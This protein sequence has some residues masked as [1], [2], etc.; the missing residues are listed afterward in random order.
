MKQCNTTSGKLPK[1]FRLRFPAFLCQ[2]RT[3]EGRRL[4]K[5]GIEMFRYKSLCPRMDGV[6]NTLTSVLKDNLIIHL[7]N[8]DMKR[9]Y[10]HNPTNDDL[11]DY[12]APRIAVR[13]MISR[14]S[15]RLM[16]VPEEDIDK[17]FAW[18]F[19]TIEERQKAIEKADKKELSRIKR[20]SICKTAQFKLAGNSIVVDCLFHIFRTLFIPNQPENEPKTAQ[21]SLFN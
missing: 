11:R 20:E 1:G 19:K 18:P 5:L 2:L 6:S 21:L 8:T 13:K 15:F 17:I 12:F 14:E 7:N 10:K 16:G 3:D 9:E 4:R